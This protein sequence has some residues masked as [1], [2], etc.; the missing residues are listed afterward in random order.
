[1]LIA[2]ISEW[3]DRRKAAVAQAAFLVLTTGLYVLAFPPFGMG[4][5]AFVF[6]APF[7]IWLRFRPS[8][9]AVG[10]SA[11]AS[12]WIA[13]L[14]L[15]FWLRNV[16]WIGTFLL[17]GFLAAHFAAWALGAAWLA[18]RTLGRGTFSGIPFVLGSAA[19]W[20]AVE[21]FRGWFLTGFPWLPLSASQWDQPIMLQSAAVFGSWALCF[22][23]V[24][25]NLGV[26]G[27]LAK[28][29]GNA[30]TR[31]RE[32]CP[33]FYLALIVLVGLTFLQF[34]QTSAQQREPAFKAGVMQPS[35]PQDQKWDNEFAWRILDQVKRQNLL[36]A[37]LD[38]D[39]IFWP[40]ATL[41]Y[42]IG[43][44][45]A[46]EAWVE[47]LAKEA[48]TPIFAGALSVGSSRQ[49]SETWWNSV[50]LVEPDTGIFR[51]PYIKRHLVP[52]GEYIPLRPMW[53]WL[54]KIVP[55]HGDI[56]PGD[57]PGLLPL[58][59]EGT[60]IEIG[61]LICYEDVFPSLARAST[62]KGAGILFVATNS[63]WYGR[64]GAAAQHMAHS[65]LRA[66]ET[67][68]VVLRVGNDGWTG[69]IDEYGN[70]RDSFEQYEIGGTAW[71]ISRDRRWIGRLTPYVK[72]GDW[73]VWAC[74]ALIAGC[75]F[76]TRSYRDEA[77]PPAEVGL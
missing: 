35:V 6:L 1:M 75:V 42:P 3:L 55:I 36:L 71:Q 64:S 18:R 20:V 57:G 68:R 27:Y 32:L 9:R 12:A 14:V 44:D 62:K 76:W 5:G 22:A 37:A 46:M 53:P 33:E 40:E 58:R 54:E 52:F 11:L 29:A 8:Y 45:V 61:T 17:A 66:V 19:L 30:A 65:V 31:R 60:K 59:L 72:Y 21:H 15:I 26:A 77:P 73:F 69:W 51:A 48:D 16:T 13:W 63:A 34:R 25:V 43:S 41:P 39:A 2:R 56:A 4:E 28:L 10:W 67:R 50:Y 47:R 24:A 23:L 49:G 70:V 7:A 74:Y 38:P